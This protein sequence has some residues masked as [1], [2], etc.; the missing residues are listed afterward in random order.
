MNENVREYNRNMWNRLVDEG[1]RWTIPVTSEE[2]AEAK[3][4]NWQI[5]LTAQKAVPRS[6]FPALEGCKILCLAS[7]GGQ[8]APILAAAGADVTVLDGSARQLDQDRF[9]AQRDSLQIRTIEGDMADLSMFADSCFDLI[10]HP[11]SNFCIPDVR[12]IW[13]EAFRVLSGGGGLL[14]GFVNPDTYLFDQDLWDQGIF[15]VKYK[16][17]FSDAR[18]LSE[19]KRQ[20]V[21]DK[22]RLFEFSHSLGDQIG[23]QLD[24]GFLL[25]ELYEDYDD[26]ELLSEY[27]PL[28]IATRAIKP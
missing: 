16:I 12:P 15:H 26:N 8:Q 4:G 5:V 17:P 13:R 24:A 3:K 19:G 22:G 1:N 7:G 14:V 18:D 9:V 11:V 27:M 20:E 2:I 10:F 23:G 6:W 25:A 21:I 28:F